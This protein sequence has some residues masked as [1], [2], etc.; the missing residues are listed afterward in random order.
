M[1]IKRFECLE[2]GCDAV[3]TAETDEELVAAVERHMAEVHDTF[4]LEDVILANSV[5]E[6]ADSG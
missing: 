1:S 3:V 5:S 2:A 4:E 6:E